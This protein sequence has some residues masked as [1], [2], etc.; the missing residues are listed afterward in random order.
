MSSSDELRDLWMRFVEAER[1]FT[2]QRMMLLRRVTELTPILVQALNKPRERS[3]ALNIVEYVGDEE[4]KHVFDSL[5]MLAS[6]VHGHTEKSREFLLSLPKQWVLENIEAR[7]EPILQHATQ[8]EYRGL[9]EL[10]LQLEQGLARRLAERALKHPDS[11]VREAGE[12][13]IER[14]A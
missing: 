3:A 6:N 10:Y 12:E 11:E 14:L 1:S 4:K 13:F 9:F 7:A 8:E 2:S 5:L